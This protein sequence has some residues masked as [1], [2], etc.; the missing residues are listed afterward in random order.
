MILEKNQYNINGN[1]EGYWEEKSH[2]WSSGI[3]YGSLTG[4]YTN[5]LKDGPWYQYTKEGNKFRLKNYHNNKLT[6]KYIS[7]HRDLNAVSCSGQYEN[8]EKYGTWNWF[9]TDGTLKQI[10]L[11]ENNGSLISIKTFK[12]NGNIGLEKIFIN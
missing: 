8:N 6:G 11:F 2:Y 10:S 12:L 9:Y 7:W 1:K 4:Y 5:G 3:N